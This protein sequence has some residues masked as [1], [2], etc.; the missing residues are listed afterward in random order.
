MSD[1]KIPPANGQFKLFVDDPVPPPDWKPWSVSFHIVTHTAAGETTIVEYPLTATD[2]DMPLV[3]RQPEAAPREFSPIQHTLESVKRFGFTHPN[4][5]HYLMVPKEFQAILILETKAVA[6]VVWEVMLQ[7]I[8]WKE[9]REPGG[10]REWAALTEGHFVRAKLL[11]RSQAGAGI[12]RALAKGYIQR[13][14][15]GKQR[16]E[17]AIRWSGSN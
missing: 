5:G 7:T 10:S 12:K 11:S 16:F 4:H 3:R 6:A 9:G 1:S 2:P 17:Y 13:R 14:K 15:I 8:G